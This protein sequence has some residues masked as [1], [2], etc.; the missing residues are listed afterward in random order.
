V[1]LYQLTNTLAAENANNATFTASGWGSTLEFT[2]KKYFKIK[3]FA[4]YI[5]TN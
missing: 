1:G 4:G 3:I 5:H 2:Y